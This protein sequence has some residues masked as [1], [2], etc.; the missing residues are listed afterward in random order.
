MT[1]Y[2][3]VLGGTY[4]KICK[5]SQIKTHR[6][7]SVAPGESSRGQ[8][9]CKRVLQ[10]LLGNLMADNYLCFSTCFSLAIYETHIFEMRRC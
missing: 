5:T 1:T 4:G 2:I 6:W 9:L 7:F 8:N 10:L 3:Y